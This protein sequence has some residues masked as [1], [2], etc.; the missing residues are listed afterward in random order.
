MN[1]ASSNAQNKQIKRTVILLA[2]IAACFYF[3]FI[4][5]TGMKG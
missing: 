2:L 4:I 5:A 3:G 1:A